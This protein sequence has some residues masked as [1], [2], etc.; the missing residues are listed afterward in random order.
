MI[1]LLLTILTGFL[2]RVDGMNRD[3]WPEHYQILSAFAVRLFMVI[4]GA[5]AALMYINGSEYITIAMCLLFGGAVAI[6]MQMDLKDWTDLNAKQILHYGVGIAG[7]FMLMIMSQNFIV[8]LVGLICLSLAGLSYP[9]LHR[10]NV[11]NYTVYCEFFSGCM[12]IAP[13]FLMHLG[14]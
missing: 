14:G 6:S 10:M 8:L 13:L 5:L 1:E 4:S 3:D 2:R 11:K 9:V 7:Y 12:H